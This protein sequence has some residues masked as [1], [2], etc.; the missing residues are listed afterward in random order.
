MT[1]VKMSMVIKPEHFERGGEVDFGIWERGT[2]RAHRLSMRR[3]AG[4]YEVYKHIF[5]TGR[6]EVVYTTRS[7]RDAVHYTNRITGYADIVEEDEVPIP[8]KRGMPSRLEIMAREIPTAPLIEEVRELE[9]R[10][11]EYPQEEPYELKPAGAPPEKFTH[12]AQIVTLAQALI[13]RHITAARMLVEGDITRA[14]RQAVIGYA[15]LEDN[16]GYDNIKDIDP[17][18]IA[19]LHEIREILRGRITPEQRLKITEILRSIGDDNLMVGIMKVCYTT[20]SIFTEWAK[21]LE[22]CPPELPPPVAVAP[23]EVPAKEQY[24]ELPYSFNE[25]KEIADT[26]GFGVDM[27]RFMRGL[28]E[29][30]TV[31]KIHTEV[32]M[33]E[34]VRYFAV[35]KRATYT[36]TLPRRLSAETPP[37]CTCV[38]YAEPKWARRLLEEWREAGVEPPE[39]ALCK[40][41]IAALQYAARCECYVPEV[42]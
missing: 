8:I 9:R 37:T 19:P 12:C 30:Y 4:R 2:P 28:K 34:A 33:P 31:C 7:L 1:L 15:I 3:R 6:D 42:S 10:L 18:G 41:I 26:I 22:I 23:P 11:G 17:E 13:R 20:Y 27:G 29:L 21:G 24:I 36:V 40:H 35:G 14:G 39:H 32:H 5:R 25:I 16:V 38:D